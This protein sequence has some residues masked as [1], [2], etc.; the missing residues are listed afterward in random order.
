M[1]QYG[2]EHGYDLGVISGTTRQQ[3]L[4]RHLGFVPFGPFARLGR[5]HLP[6]HVPDVG[7]L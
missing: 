3:R 5:G 6:A 4:Y 1:W 7:K 2:L